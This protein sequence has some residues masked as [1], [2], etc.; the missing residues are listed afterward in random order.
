M[1]PCRS[2]IPR[3]R[4]LASQRET[5]TPARRKRRGAPPA[6]RPRR[7]ATARAD[8]A[9]VCRAAFLSTFFFLLCGRHATTLAQREK[10][11]A[12]WHRELF[13][14]VQSR[15]EFLLLVPLRLTLR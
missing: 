9:L 15:R 13:D 11:A 8:P 3:S 2:E 1:P 12:A 6:L 10:R 7:S 5:E 4:S 14:L